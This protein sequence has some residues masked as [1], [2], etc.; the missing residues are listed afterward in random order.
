MHL[1]TQDL[2]KKVV[3]GTVQ[4]GKAYGINNK[5]GQ[6]TRNQSLDILQKSLD[7]GIQFFDT[8]NNY[9]VSQGILAEFFGSINHAHHILSKGALGEEGLRGAVEYSLQRLQVSTIYS[10]SLHDFSEISKVN[11]RAV[12]ELKNLGLINK[13]GV[14]V[15]T[16]EEVVKAASCDYVDIIQLPFSILDNWSQRGD[17]IEYAKGKGREIHVRSIFLQGLFMSQDQLSLDKFRE[18]REA[19]K[20]VED[21]AL[22][23]GL[24][25]YE[26]ALLYPLSIKS[27]DKV[28]FGTE[29]ISQ[30]KENLEVLK[31]GRLNESIVSR[32]N[33]LE[34]ENSQMLNPQNW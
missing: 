11:S 34:I 14:S 9:G 26:V 10:F 25:V 23:V 19:I 33:S 4:L 2:I 17:A 29:T 6:P 28:L 7:S 20:K 15:Y 22:S 27:I 8:A 3:L 12:D 13:F 32:I 30:L 18:I 24:T 16:S 31:K 5:L 21:I 1:E